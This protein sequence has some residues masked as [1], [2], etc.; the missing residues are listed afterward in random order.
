MPS[1]KQS[2]MSITTENKRK[3]LKQAANDP[4]DSDDS[5]SLGEEDTEY[6]TETSDSS[7]VPPSKSNKNKKT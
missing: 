1:I 5:V 4:P 3:R 2:T 7:Y 6:E